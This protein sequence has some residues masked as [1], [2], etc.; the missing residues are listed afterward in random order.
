MSAEGLTQLQRGDVVRKDTGDYSFVGTVVHVFFKLD[1]KT[2]RV[3]VEDDRGLLLIMN[4][5]QLK[6]VS[7]TRGPFQSPPGRPPNPQRSDG[8]CEGTIT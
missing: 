4:L 7:S 3:I 1:D 2:I 8:T 6:V 5:N